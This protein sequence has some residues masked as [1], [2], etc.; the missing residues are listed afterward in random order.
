MAT[1]YRRGDT[2]APTLPYNTTG[3]A[4][5]ALAGIATILKAC[6]VSGYG[7]K[8]A[9][10]W[11]LIAEAATYLVLRNGAHTGYLYLVVTDTYYIDVYL[12]ETYT[13]ITS[14]VPT[15]DGTRSGSGGVRQNFYM[16]Y[17]MYSASVSSWFVV[18][19]ANTFV[20]NVTGHHTNGALNRLVS[21]GVFALYAGLDSVGNFISL[22]GVNQR[23]TQEVARF[24]FQGFTALK[25]PATGLLLGATAALAV[26]TPGL[27][28]GGYTGHSY[29]SYVDTVSVLSEAAMCPHIWVANGRTGQLRGLMCVPELLCSST[30]AIGQTFGTAALTHNTLATPL[31][32]GDA[33]TYFAGAKQY[34]LVLGSYICT[35]NP[36][37]W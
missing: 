2:G 35:N 22:G 20:I 17:L 34:D 12:S 36:E 13:G 3:N 4:T 25:D 21:N 37:F 5:T 33:Y 26:Q 30:T 7:S 6:L 16:Q 23:A 24:S 10:G 27:A 14:N 11:E 32:L 8:P 31:N 1:A 19:D 28:L 9:A 18:A 29:T 15:G